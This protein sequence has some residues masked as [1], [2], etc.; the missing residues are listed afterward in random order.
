MSTHS[1]YS[2]EE[3]NNNGLSHNQKEE[4]AVP[5]VLVV[6]DD[7]TVRMLMREVLEQADFRVEEVENG[8][9][10]LAVFPH[11]QP[12]IVL[13]DVMMPA[14]DGF[15]TC[16]A[17]RRL[18]GGEQIP[19]LMVTGLDDLDSIT[20]AFEVGATDFV[21]KPINWVIL[22]HRL[23][24]LLRASR[25]MEELRENREALRQACEAAQAAARLKSEF[26]ATISHELR[27]PMHGVIGM[28]G[29]LLETAL[30]SEQREYAES[31]KHSAVALL[32]IINDI[33][34][35]SKIE[36]GKL[37]V[38]CLDFDLRATLKETLELFTIPAQKKGIALACHLSADLPTVLRGDPGRLRQ[39]FTNLL[40]NAVKFTDHGEVVVRVVLTQT[41]STHVM[42]RFAVTDTGIGI[43][44][45]YRDRLFQP[46]SQGDATT[47]RKYGGTGLGLVISKQ[48]TKL[49]GGE[50]GMESEPG[51]GS[52]FWWTVRFERPQAC[53]QSLSSPAGSGLHER[54]GPV[55]ALSPTLQGRR[56]LVADDNVINQKLA[57]RLLEKLGCR[58]EVAATGQEVLA[59]LRR[60]SYAAVL[61]DCLMPEMDGFTAARRIREGEDAA[62]AAGAS[63]AAPPRLPIIAMTANAMPGDKER[64]LEAGMDDY[65]AK[66]ITPAELRATLERWLSQP[67]TTASDV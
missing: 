38:E 48:L 13:L 28:T 1:A 49:M 50:I 59:A 40:G 16:T 24:Y 47:T 46:F 63:T 55:A 62:P 67:G 22:S 53:A 19:I 23:R 5:V 54:S 12:D 21:T 37:A 61:M 6:D 4:R 17:L 7:F 31:V 25:T 41:T 9:Q 42:V 3:Q 18:P 64:C 58:V 36:A 66:P 65:L 11:L 2:L 35:F 15:A 44:P 30:T 51:R 10:A 8:V 57:V 39:I 20:R 56:I 34:D 27:T 43:A 26:V 52:T 14:M 45:E 32:S 60:Q 29:L 33:L